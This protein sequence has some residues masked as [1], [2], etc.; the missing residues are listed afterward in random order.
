MVTNINDFNKY[1]LKN[2][3]NLMIQS[4]LVNEANK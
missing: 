2:E 1:P 4:V 3:N